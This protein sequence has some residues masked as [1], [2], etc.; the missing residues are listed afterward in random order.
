LLVEVVEHQHLHLDILQDLMVVS[1]AVDK[2][3]VIIH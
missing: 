3:P 1:V 2:V